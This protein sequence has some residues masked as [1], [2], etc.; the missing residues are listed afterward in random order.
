MRDNFLNASCNIS[1]L[2]LQISVFIF[3]KFIIKCVIIIV[4]II[5]CIIK[6]DAIISITY[7][8]L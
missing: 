3:E 8:L 1:L 6:S 4:S 2:L 5:K 7:S